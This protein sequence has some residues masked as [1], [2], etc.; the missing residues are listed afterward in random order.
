[1]PIDQRAD[2]TRPEAVRLDQLEDRV[3]ERLLIVRRLHAVD[4][5]RVEEPP[6][7]GVD[8]EAGRPPPRLVAARALEDAAAVMYDVG[9]DVD[10]GLR[11]VDERAI[12]PDLAGARERH[13]RTPCRNS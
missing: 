12:H 10:G 7:M 3:R 11:P 8:P 5:G 2:V 1:A 6:D 9:G 4:A 13:G